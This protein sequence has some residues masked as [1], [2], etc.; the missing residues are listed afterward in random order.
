M[1]KSAASRAYDIFA[2]DDY[3][4][5]T[6]SIAYWRNLFRGVMRAAQPK[7]VWAVIQ[8]FGH[9][10][11]KHDWVLPT[12]EEIRCMTYISVV[13][14]AQ[15]ILFYSHCRKGAPFYICDRTEHWAFVQ[16]LGSELQTLS[17]V[18]LSAAVNE[19]VSV[20]NKLID[21][22]LRKHDL[23][24]NPAS[25]ELY[26]IAANMAHK[27]PAAERHFPGVKQ[28]DVRIFLK[29][30]DNGEAEL[31]GAAGSGSAQAGRRI[32]IHLGTFSDDFD[33]YA[34]H[35]YKISKRGGEP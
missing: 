34:V 7:P 14:G 17:P 35:I 20:E 6:A 23:A 29:D 3:P 16:R 2:Y 13:A 9:A 30:V 15:G 22:T 27:A 12:P 10:D 18:L 33:P 11:P 21:V 5:G 28:V 8:A 19:R 25:R 4:I 32:P 31:V 26:L 1:T 24:G